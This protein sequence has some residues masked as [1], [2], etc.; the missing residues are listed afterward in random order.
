M[1]DAVPQLSAALARWHDVYMLLGTAAATMVGLLFVAASVGASVFSG[2]RPA[3]LRFFV[4]ATVVNFTVI[5][6]ACLIGLSPVEG[7]RTFGALIALV[8]L[9]GLGY[10]ALAWR[11][12]AREKILDKV[13]LEDRAWYGVLPVVGHTI[14]A[15]AGVAL[16]LSKT[17]GLDVLALAQALLLVVGI[18]NAW[19]I[20][21]WVVGKKIG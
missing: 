14:E 4:S 8:G 5:L 18:H 13:D 7:W 11:E 9:F 3:G 19:D 21:I 17:E 6:I 1:P 12:V 10:Y 16:A 20:T 2:N 15:A